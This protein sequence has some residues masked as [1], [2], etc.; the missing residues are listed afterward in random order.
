[1]KNLL[2]QMEALDK[3]KLLDQRSQQILHTV[4]C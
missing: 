1:M 4:R 3:K 2:G